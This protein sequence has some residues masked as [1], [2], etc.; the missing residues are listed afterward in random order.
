MLAICLSVDS[1]QITSRHFM[2]RG[3][4]CILAV[5]EKYL[6][7]RF[8]RAAP[9]YLNRQCA[10]REAF[11]HCITG[12]LPG[13]QRSSKTS[14]TARSKPETVLGGTRA[15]GGTHHLKSSCINLSSM[16]AIS[17]ISARESPAFAIDMAPRTFAT[18]RW[19]KVVSS[20]LKSSSTEA[21]MQ[22][23]TLIDDGEYELVH[24]LELQ[25]PSFK[26]RAVAPSCA[27]LEAPTSSAV[28]TAVR[29]RCA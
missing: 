21:E 1:M 14:S 4:H 29:S 17:I 10:R 8:R 23:D 3:L 2:V 25:K 27:A 11:V 9:S 18:R 7:I 6:C 19:G 13:R 24:I 16:E 12:E 5:P 22:G 15:N 26:T 20:V 28:C